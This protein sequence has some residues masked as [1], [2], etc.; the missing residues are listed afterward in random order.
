[1]GTDIRRVPFA[2]IDIAGQYGS[3]T[4]APRITEQMA[5]QADAIDSAGRTKDALAR[6][7]TA[8]GGEMW[9]F[10]TPDWSKDTF[11]MDPHGEM[12]RLGDPP[13]RLMPIQDAVEPTNGLDA[14]NGPQSE[15]PSA[16][17]SASSGGV[18]S[19]GE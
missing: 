2:T 14:T 1:M 19:S 4:A 9:N 3:R 16:D 5:A 15:A 10:G 11:Q 13:A 6:L 18:E 7:R 8:P 12:N 17:D